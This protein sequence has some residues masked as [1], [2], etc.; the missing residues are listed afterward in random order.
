MVDE[1]KGK[2]TLV[3]F[4]FSKFLKK[5]RDFRSFTKCGTPG[6]IAPEILRQT[7]REAGGYRVGYGFESD[8]WSVGVLMCE[9]IGGF[10]PFFCSDPLKMQENILKLQINWPKNMDTIMKS[11]C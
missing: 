2:L 7:D 11:L 4:G 8:V 1:L 6:Y 3:D 5:E 9:L 10:N